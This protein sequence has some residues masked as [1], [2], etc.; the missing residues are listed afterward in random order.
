M[1]FASLRR[2]LPV[3]D[4]IGPMGGDPPLMRGLAPIGP[5]GLRVVIAGAT[6]QLYS[7]LLFHF[8]SPGASCV[9]ASF[10]TGRAPR[11]GPRICLLGWRVKPDGN[12]CMQRPSYMLTNE[13]FVL[14][15]MRMAIDLLRIAHV[16]NYDLDWRGRAIAVRP[17]ILTFRL[18]PRQGRFRARKRKYGRLPG[19]YSGK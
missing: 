15:T 17:A 11:I 19:R 14:P 5:E 16:A 7:E 6:Q 10:F 12:A 8:G 9:E 18:R 4:H 3:A 2:N 1:L 13:G